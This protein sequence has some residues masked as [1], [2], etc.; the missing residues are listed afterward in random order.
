MKRFRS[1]QNS[2]SKEQILGMRL[3]LSSCLVLMVMLFQF[4]WIT[5]SVAQTTQ[6]SMLEIKKTEITNTV[7]NIVCTLDA[8]KQDYMAKYTDVTNEQVKEHLYQCLRRW[9][10]SSSFE[11]GAYPWVK[12]LLSFEG[13]D[14]YARRLIHPGEPETEGMYL[15]T[16]KDDGNGYYLY[17]EELEELKEN[18]WVYH[19]YLFKKLNSDEVTKKIAYTQLYSD[20]N[21]MISMGVHIDDLDVYVEEA[22]TRILPY[23]IEGILILE[24]ILI[25][26]YILLYRLQRDQ[27]RIGEQL[28]KNQVESDHL[29]GAGSRRYGDSLIQ[30]YYHMFR[31]R[32]KNILVMMADI[33]YF[34]KVN[35]TYGHE[36][37]DVA[38]QRFS[39]AIQSSLR[40]QD[41]LIRWGGDEFVCMFEY[42]SHMNV[43]GIG[44]KLLAAIH[45][46]QIETERGVVRLTSSMGFTI[47]HETDNSVEDIMKR[48]DNALYE[49]KKQGRN[50]YVIDI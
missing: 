7:K 26:G 25:A 37:G 15:S 22:R 41:K 36:I 9:I 30:V 21:W 27:Y 14:N 44:D 48:V 6:A 17:R 19:E 47:F 40:A 28:L 4:R 20:Y 29:T 10:Y 35:D 43:S 13:G 31:K 49:A 11:D 45:G 2:L 24:G 46:I 42:D 5:H 33:D 23:A 34:K 32:K 18:G 38:L 50:R 16:D 8:E 12:E 3:V 39:A 1:W